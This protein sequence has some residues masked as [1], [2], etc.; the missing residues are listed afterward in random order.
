MDI[1]AMAAFVPSAIDVVR[2]PVC[3]LIHFF[4]L[5]NNSR[6]SGDSLLINVGLV[7]FGICMKRHL[8]L[9]VPVRH[10]TEEEPE[11]MNNEQKRIYE[12]R[13]CTFLSFSS[14]FFSFFL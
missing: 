13:A 8:E 11:R 3:A 6:F 10:M 4:Y 7:E 1:A 12:H 14:S 9:K 5:E 2:V